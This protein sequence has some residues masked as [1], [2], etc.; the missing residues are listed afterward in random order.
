[1]NE[2]PGGGKSRAGLA[3][4]LRDLPRSG[5]R[6][7]MDLAATIPNV[8]HLEVG[9]PDFPTPPHI[10]E[11]AVRAARDGYTKY[12]PSR[13]YLSLREALCEKLERQNKVSAAPNDVIFT[14]GGVGA[15][16]EAFMALVEPN[17]VVLIPDPGWPH[18]EAMVL[19]AGGRPVRYPLLL[20]RGF[21]PDLQALEE[22]ATRTAAKAI[23]INSPG[24]PT[25]GVFGRATVEAIC[26]IADRSGAYIVSDECYEAITFGTDHVSPASLLPERVFSAWSFSKTYAMTG[27]RAGYLLTPPGLGAEVTK[28]QEPV[29]SCATG[30]VQKA[31]EAALIGPQECVSEMVSAYRD[32]RDLIVRLLEGTSLLLAVPQGAFYAMVDI[33]AAGRDS[34]AFVRWLLTEKG[35]AVAPG[36]TFGPSADRAVRVSLAS[37]RRSLAEGVGRLAEALGQQPR[38]VELAVSGR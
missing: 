6:E 11:A 24:N 2:L 10:V 35:V 22:L 15:L 38:G 5:I 1:V 25:G 8:I 20:E 33:S 26:A 30:I 21:E 18:T 27:W 23:Y 14:V 19:L 28:I 36:S 37:G 16:F 4:R 7:V 3:S 32:R 12:T 29:I 9:E 34:R 31:A 13:G 17:D